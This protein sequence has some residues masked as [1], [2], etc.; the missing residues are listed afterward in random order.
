MLDHD[1]ATGF[2][3]FIPLS[4][5]VLKEFLKAQKILNKIVFWRSGSKNADFH[6][7]DRQWKMTNM[8]FFA[9]FLWEQPFLI[10]KIYENKKI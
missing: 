8:I 6:E 1:I 3:K 5:A 2:R 4:R 10:E 9:I 7:I